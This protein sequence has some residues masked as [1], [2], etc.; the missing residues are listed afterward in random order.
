MKIKKQ[1]YLLGLLVGLVAFI[2]CS[3]D[4]LIKPTPSPDAPAGTQ[5]VYFPESNKSAFEFMPVDP[6]E[7]TLTIARSVSEGAV[8]V[9]LIQEVNDDNVFVV[10]SSVSFAAGETEVTFKVTFPD[11]EVGKTYNLEL[12]VE[13][14]E[15]VNPYVEGVPYVKT[16]AI[17]VEWKPLKEPMVMVDGTVSNFFGVGFPAWYVYAEKADIGKVTRYRFKNAYKV[18]TGEW[19]IN[20]EG[21][22]QYYPTADKD[23]IFDGYYYNAPGDFDESN[24]YV[25]TIEIGGEHGGANDV[26]MYSHFNGVDWGYGMFNIGSVYGNLSDNKD[27][28]P[29]GTLKDS[30][31]TFPE[32]SLYSAMLDYNDFGKY[33]AA[34]PTII[35]LSKNVYM[36][37]NLAID[38]FNDVE[39][40]IGA[41]KDGTFKSEAYDDDTWAQT[42]LKAIDADPENKDSDYKDLFYLPNLYEDDFGLAFYYKNKAIL[43]PESQPTGLKVFGKEV[44]VSQSDD[45]K[46]AYIVGSEEEIDEDL[47]EGDKGYDPDAGTDRYVFGLRFHYKD[48]TNLGDFEE[49]LLLTEED[50][51][52]PTMNSRKGTHRFEIQGKTLPKELKRNVRRTVIF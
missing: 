22:E 45:V 20:A 38:S 30:I 49:K 35:Y 15:Y 8:D 47:K 6:T 51:V 44:F 5:G 10:P 13:G 9:P 27:S 17:R 21:K 42:M 37:A 16:N 7:F 32:N 52:T 28:Y 11:A 1:L 23:G 43:I 31:I 46:S 40:T 48:G 39:Y 4:D 34:D 50:E 19:G 36:A 24:D 41:V 33:P 3:E 12:N 2:G 26:F 29:L 18:P 14:D 25:T